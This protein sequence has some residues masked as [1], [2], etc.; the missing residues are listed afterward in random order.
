MEAPE[1]TPEADQA[2]KDA[3]PKLRVGRIEIGI[4]IVVQIIVLLAMVMMVNYLASKYFKRWNWVRGERSE[5]SEMTR[6][7]MGNLSKPMKAIVFFS[8]KTLEVNGDARSLL[9]EYEFAARGKLSIEDVDPEEN[10][11]RAR[12]LAVKYKFAG[13]ENL[14]ILDYDGRSKFINTT[15]MAEME[16]RD[17]MAEIQARMQ[18]QQL[19][20]PQMIAFQGEEIL[21]NEIL[22]LIEPKQNKLYLVNGHGEFDTNGRKIQTFIEYTKRQNLLLENLT[23]ADVDKIPADANMVLILGPKF[24]M[25][26]RDLKV[27]SDYWD[28]KGRV[29]I[30]VG[31]TGGKTPDLFA[32][33]AA[34]GVKAKDDYVLRVVDMGSAMQVQSGGV[35]SSTESAI[36]SGL[37]GI[38]IEMLGATQSLELDRAKETRENLKLTG[39]MVSPKGFWGDVEFN[40]GGDEVPIFD[41]KKDHEGPLTLAVQVEKGASTDPN[42]KLETSR[43]VVVGNS[44]FVSDDGLRT[45]PLSV[46]VASNCIN[47]LLNRELL[48][49]VPPKIKKRATLS[50]PIEKL[51]SIRLWVILY[52]P[53]VVALFGLY[54]LCARHGKNLLIVTAWVATAFLVIVG[55]WYVLLWQLGM[56]DAKTVPRNLII[57]IGAAASLAAVSIVINYYEN[58]K[59]TAA[60]N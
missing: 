30:A 13:V 7:V 40:V 27:L 38:S 35:V 15:D 9:R 5:L 19:P 4:N 2:P 39:L 51:N 28:A 42:V 24:D 48:I 52:I 60:K 20:P 17:Q 50:L 16:E 57:A 47:W 45:G 49:K 37:E 1:T 44:D 6:S 3:P 54:F 8:D 14:I 36:T 31:K 56:E 33:L 46:N 12:E 25:S 11:A 22:S 29:F 21:T 10:Y 43:L 59:R 26:E 53:L 23:I 58:Q 18:G 34:R 41:P 32:W 55:C